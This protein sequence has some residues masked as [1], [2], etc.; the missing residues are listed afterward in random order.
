M[1]HVFDL[2]GQRG[3]MWNIGIK[4]D[5][6]L[7]RV[8]N[9]WPV[10]TGFCCLPVFIKVLHKQED[11]IHSN[12]QQKHRWPILCA[13]VDPLLKKPDAPQK[14]TMKQ[15]LTHLPT[16]HP[17]IT[18]HLVYIVHCTRWKKASDPK[19]ISWE[20][21]SSALRVLQQKASAPA[22]SLSLPCSKYRGAHPR[23]CKLQSPKP[24]T[25]VVL[26]QGHVWSPLTA[27]CLCVYTSKLAKYTHVQTYTQTKI[28]I[29]H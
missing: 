4:S 13:M 7:F 2:G 29:F 18:T 6:P 23:Q 16:L 5:S 21:L 9:R 20:V 25:R 10:S 1:P 19:L 22:T 12:Q 8:L 15:L 27:L 17:P 3:R 24:G 14:K 26:Q 28:I 11:K